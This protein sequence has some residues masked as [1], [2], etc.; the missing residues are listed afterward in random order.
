MAR[1]SRMHVFGTKVKRSQLRAFGLTLAACFRK[2]DLD[3]LRFPIA[4][5]SFTILTYYFPEE[6]RAA[7]NALDA[8][9]IGSQLAIALPRDWRKLAML[10]LW[11]EWCHAEIGAEIIKNCDRSKLLQQIRRFVSPNADEF[12]SLLFFLA[13]GSDSFEPWFAD[14]LKEIVRKACFA[15]DDGAKLILGAYAKLDP[16][17]SSALAEELDI[18]P[19]VIQD[20]VEPN[21]ADKALDPVRQKYLELEALGQD[22]DLDLT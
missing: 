5:T 21:E 15:K 9:K 12:R 18:E 11:A 16:I 2:A 20:K 13:R 7:L 6:A 3:N 4:G 19:E 14:G 8:R 1:R 10:T 22:Y 17:A